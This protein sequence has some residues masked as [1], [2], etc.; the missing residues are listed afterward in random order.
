MFPS[1]NDICRYYNKR[2]LSFCQ[3]S[4]K[5]FLALI[6]IFW[7]PD[8]RN[9]EGGFGLV[10]QIGLPESHFQFFF[11]DFFQIQETLDA[12]RT[13]LGLDFRDPYLLSY[14][15]VESN[16]YLTDRILD[17]NNGVVVGIRYA[18]AGGPFGGSSVPSDWFIL[19][20]VG[21]V[22]LMMA[23]AMRAFARQDP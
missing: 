9:P 5:F 10:I 14:L 17:P 3:A 13:L 4:Q 6:L 18:I 12:N 20:A 21:Y 22:L 7:Y 19:Y 23:L 1:C 11:F 8:F 15:K 16:L 2:Q